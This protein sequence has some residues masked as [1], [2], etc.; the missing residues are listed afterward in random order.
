MELTRKPNVLHVDRGSR[1][2][3]WDNSVMKR[4]IKNKSNGLTLKV[5]K[6]GS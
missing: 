5:K 3:A 2:I 4:T 1:Q 6:F